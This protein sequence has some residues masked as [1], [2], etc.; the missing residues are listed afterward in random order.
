MP[1]EPQSLTLEKPGY[2]QTNIQSKKAEENFE[3]RS[4][5]YLMTVK[6]AGDKFYL[7]EVALV[8]AD[9]ECEG[10]AGR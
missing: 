2:V 8:N 9:S 5:L 3:T 10:R 1:L 7:L 6:I 4:L